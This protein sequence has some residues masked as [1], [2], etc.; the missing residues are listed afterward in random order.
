MYVLQFKHILKFLDYE[1]LEY[2][3][4]ISLYLDNLFNNRAV[5]P[6]YVVQEIKFFRYSASL[7]LLDEEIA[8][9]FIARIRKLNKEMMNRAIRTCITAEQMDAIRFLNECQEK[10]KNRNIIS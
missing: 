2:I 5:E 7:F 9:L 10:H 8:G 3:E 6:K 1:D 4:L